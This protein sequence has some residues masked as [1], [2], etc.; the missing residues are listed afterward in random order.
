[1]PAV[2]PARRE[3]LP[4]I[5]AISN[6]AA[7][8]TP[9]NFAVEPESLE[10]WQ[11]DWDATH[12]MFPWCVAV[13]DGDVMVGFARASPWKGRCAY[14]W[15]A[16]TTVYVKPEHHGQ[17]LGRALY[18]QLID[19]LAAQG[20]RTLMGGITM[21]NDASVRLHESFGFR[22]VALLERVGWKFDRWHDVGYWEL[23]LG[24]DEPPAALRTVQAV[25]TGAS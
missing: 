25:I 4:A 3:D 1:M 14:L 24:G 5:L 2:R 12:E 17:G 10:S 11:R 16:E 15:S 22:K 21:P 23:Q 6:Q 13:D 9:A 19:T 7:L 8:T 20:Y 18:R